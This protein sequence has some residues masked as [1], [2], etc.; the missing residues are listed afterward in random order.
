MKEITYEEWQKNPTPRIMWVWDED[1]TYKIK[2]EVVYCC[3]VARVKYPIVAL[4]EGITEGSQCVKVY[5]HCAEIEKFNSLK[6]CQNC[7]YFNNRNA[8]LYLR[9][10]KGKCW[11][12]GV[13]NKNFKRSAE[14]KRKLKE[15]GIKV[16]K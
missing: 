14:S 7:K 13:E 3:D 2:A 9:H 11:T 1:M 10:R 4:S 5:K 16:E 15:L 6:T 8:D 12:C